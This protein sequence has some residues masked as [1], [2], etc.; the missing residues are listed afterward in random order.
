MHGVSDERFHRGSSTP[1]GDHSYWTFE[2]M[3]AAKRTA[4][5][6]VF[7][8]GLNGSKCCFSGKLLPQAFFSTRKQAKR[9][10]SLAT[11]RVQSGLAESS[12]VNCAK[13]T[14]QSMP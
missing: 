1:Q 6:G 4:V 8:D 10:R 7:I 5:M 3:Q 9:Q 11:L 2:D 12:T 14:E 13:P